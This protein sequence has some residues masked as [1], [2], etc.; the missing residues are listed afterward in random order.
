MAPHAVATIAALED[1]LTIP[2]LAL[3]LTLHPFFHAPQGLLKHS[4]SSLVT[5]GIVSNFQDYIFDELLVK[6]IGSIL[7]FCDFRLVIMGYVCV[8]KTTKVF[9]N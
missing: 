7:L 5:G 3:V 6:Y 9:Q 1:A 8:L 4:L 2:V